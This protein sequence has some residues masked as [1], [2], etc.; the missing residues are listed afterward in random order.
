MTPYRIGAE[1][2][3]SCFICGDVD[4]CR[5]M[6]RLRLRFKA[7]AT[8][9]PPLLQHLIYSKFRRS[10]VVI[11]LGLAMWGSLF[12][13]I[14]DI[15]QLQWTQSPPSVS[16]IKTLSGLQQKYQDAALYPVYHCSLPDAQ[17]S[18]RRN[19]SLDIEAECCTEPFAETVDVLLCSSR[20]ACHGSS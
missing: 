20:E 10:L 6:P 19:T 12:P 4:P 18:S 5:E 16:K 3:K 7:A 13:I 2:D 14:L 11:S 9:E 17:Y 8:L 15:N 1:A